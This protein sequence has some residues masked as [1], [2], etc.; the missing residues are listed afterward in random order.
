FRERIAAPIWQSHRVHLTA[1]L[2]FAAITFLP[3][4]RFGFV[5]HDDP[6]YV[7]DNSHVSTGLSRANTLWAL[8]AL[9]GEISYWHPLTWLSHQLDCQLFGLRPGPHHL[10]SV[11]LHLG[12]AVLLLG[13]L[14]RTGFTASVALF[15]AG[16]FALHPLQVES[17]VWIAERK[18]V[19]YAFFW[20]AALSAYVRFRQSGRCRQYVLSLGC[21]AAALMSKPTAVTLPLAFLLLEMLPPFPTSFQPTSIGRLIRLLLP[22]AVLSLLASGLALEAQDQLGALPNLDALPLSHRADNVLVG[23]AAYLRR[24][25]LPCGLCV[26]YVSAAPPGGGAVL[27]AGGVL[28]FVTAAAVRWRR[29][30]PT[31]LFGWLWFLLLLM[32]NIGLVQAGPQNTADRYTY[33]PLVGLCIMLV[34]AAHTCPKPL[35]LGRMLPALGLGALLACA[36]LSARQLSYW[37]DSL[38]LFQ[39]AVASDPDNWVTRLGL[40]MAL[41]EQ[42]RWDEALRHLDAALALPGNKFETEKRLGICYQWKGELAQAAT[43]YER[44]LRLRPTSLEARRLLALLAQSG[45]SSAP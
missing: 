45:R 35:W 39:H 43:H 32:P 31:F 40:G 33:I 15:I 7:Y 25:L 42:Q 26:S 11:W 16:L 18:D 6:Q 24:A 23:Y 36:A 37:R 9:H 2:A 10:T 3:V 28:T 44:A 21:L 19:L 22:F 29:R 14:R 5:N 4:A 13:V 38:S 8:T 12:N 20:L 34:S 17:V 30:M 1:V 27:G 41:T